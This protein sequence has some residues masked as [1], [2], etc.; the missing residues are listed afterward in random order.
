MRVY[1]T[2]PNTIATDGVDVV[3]LPVEEL[4]NSEKLWKRILGELHIGWVASREIFRSR[5]G[6]DY[7]IISVPA[8]LTGIVLSGMSR[9]Y[10]VPYA[11]ELRDIYPQVYA[12]AGLIKRGSAIY[13]V[14]SHLSRRAYEHATCVVTATRGLEKAVREE[15]PEANVHCVYNGFPAEFLDRESRK[16]ERFTVCFHGVLGFFQDIETLIRVAAALQEHEIDVVV[17]GYGRQEGLLRKGTPGN[18]TFHGRLPYDQTISE[19]EKCH[20]GLCLRKDDGISKDAFP[21]KVWE[22]LGLGIPSIV[23][24][25]CEAGDFLED[26]RCGFQLDSGQVPQIVGKILDLKNDAD[27]L[28][29]LSQNCR[30]A[31]KLFTRKK[32]G[33]EA[34]ELILKSVSRGNGHS[35]SYP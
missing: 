34:A 5:N 18:L 17:I 24:P 16:H 19:V 28:A 11:L 8:Y 7:L 31:R 6:C 4:E 26:K 15:S 29:G 32:L 30:E 2:T 33:A 20:L 23:T 1:T 13:R 25:R 9:L 27:Q 10:K 35:R 12:E 21:V 14:F 3:E 22:Y